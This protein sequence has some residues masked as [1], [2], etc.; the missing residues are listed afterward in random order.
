VLYQPITVKPNSERRL[1]AF[2]V[3]KLTLQAD[4]YQWEF[5]PVS[6]GGDSGSGTCH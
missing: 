6:G 3:L 5:I 1:T 2:G 4:S